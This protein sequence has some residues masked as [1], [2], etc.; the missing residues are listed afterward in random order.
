MTYY[1]KGNTPVIQALYPVTG[2][3]L[4]KNQSYQLS[5]KL[6]SGNGTPTFSLVG[7]PAGAKIT[8]D[9]LLTIQTSFAS[10]SLQVKAEIGSSSV[11][12]TYTIS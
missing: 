12:N 5:W 2:S 10:G 9:G 4:D 6:S 1:I 8:P 11:T 3:T 7:T